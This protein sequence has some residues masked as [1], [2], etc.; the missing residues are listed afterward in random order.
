MYFKLMF[1][2]IIWYSLFELNFGV[3]FFAWQARKKAHEWLEE[4]TF[5]TPVDI[6]E[7]LKGKP[8]EPGE[9]STEKEE[10]TDNDKPEINKN[11]TVEVISF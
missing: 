10:K 9:E 11:K 3:G 5:S 2:T 8:G 6:E 7:K 1:R 4:A